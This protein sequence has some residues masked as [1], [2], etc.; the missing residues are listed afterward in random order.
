MNDLLPVD[1][2]LDNFTP[3]DE[4]RTW[5]TEFKAILNFNPPHVGKLW[6]D[7]EENGMRVPV[8]LGD[9]GRVWN[10]H[11]RLLIARLLDMQE[12]PVVH[13]QDGYTDEEAGL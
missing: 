11:H 10:G 8:L 5:D 3:G 6:T 12:V 4:D 9:D 1:Y 13:A 7:I 2:I